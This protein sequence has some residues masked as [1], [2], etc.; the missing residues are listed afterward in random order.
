MAGAAR[1]RRPGAQQGRVAVAGKPAASATRRGTRAPPG[2][3][4]PRRAPGRPRPRGHRRGRRGAHRPG[5]VGPVRAVLQPPAG[6]RRGPLRVGHDHRPR[7]PRRDRQGRRPD[8][9]RPAPPG[10]PGSGRPRRS[11]GPRAHRGH[12]VRIRPGRRTARPRPV[13]RQRDGPQGGDDGRGARNR[14]R[15]R[16]L[17]LGLRCR[18]RH[19]RT[20]GPG[21]VPGLPAGPAGDLRLRHGDYHGYLG[22][23]VGVLRRARL[24]AAD[25]TARHACPGQPG[26]GRVVAVRCLGG[27]Q[28]GMHHVGCTIAVA[29]GA[30]S[31]YQKA[32]L[33]TGQRVRLRE[34]LS[35]APG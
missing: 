26:N 15:I 33:R 18:R 29:R 17:L 9:A 2:P 8:H 12:G 3:A 28:R 23:P 32:I 22:E 11:M 35:R 20:P 7:P 30:A 6:P 14:A 16:L 4:D 34:V 19:G 25:G 10:G 24:P 31:V 13:S 1:D 21:A 5:P 27:A